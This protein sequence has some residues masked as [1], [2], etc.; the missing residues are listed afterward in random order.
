MESMLDQPPTIR[1]HDS[2]PFDGVT[3]RR[4]TDT[5]RHIEGMSVSAARSFRDTGHLLKRD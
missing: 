4:L 1:E 5:M 2:R 3:K